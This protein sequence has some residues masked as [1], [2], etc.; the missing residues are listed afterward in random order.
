MGKQLSFLKC[1]CPSSCLVVV[2]NKLILLDKQ[3]VPGSTSEVLVTSSDSRIRV[4]DGVDLVHK[5]KGTLHCL[6]LTENL[7]AVIFQAG[8]YVLQ[9]TVTY[10][11]D[12]KFGHKTILL[13]IYISYE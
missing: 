2:L 13:Y 1:N 3:F 9:M 12:C 4:I 10:R 8:D 7:S 11:T 6:M 5:F